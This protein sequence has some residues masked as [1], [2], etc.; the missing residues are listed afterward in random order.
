MDEQRND[1][2]VHH[3]HQAISLVI[4]ED[5]PDTR[6]AFAAMSTAP[7]LQLLGEAGSLHEVHRLLGNGLIPN[8]LILDLGLPD[9][10]GRELIPELRNSAPAVKVLVATVFGDEASIVGALEAGAC[11]YLLK[12]I[13]PDEFVRA[14][15]AAQAGD[16]PISPAVARVLVKRFVQPS[17]K[18]TAPLVDALSRREVQVLTLIAQGYTV[19]ELAEQLHLSVHTVTTHMKNIYQKLA[20]NNRV[21]AVN[22]ARSTGQI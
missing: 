12:D 16:C 7:S 9:G 6:A 17:S 2:D 1:E 10:D 18:S 19:P 20:V 14:V 5:D 15:H 11:G 21:Q 13:L 3:A 22:K 8:V 4:V